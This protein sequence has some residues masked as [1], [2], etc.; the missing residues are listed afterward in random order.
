V[1]RRLIGAAGLVLLAMTSAGCSRWDGQ[2]P[3]VL[4]DAEHAGTKLLVPDAHA[5]ACRTRVLGLDVGEPSSPL[6]RAV[7]TLLAVDPEADALLNL[8]VAARGLALGVFERSRVA[9][10]PTS[11]VPRPSY[12]SL[13]PPGTRVTTDDT[14]DALRGVGQCEIRRTPGQEVR[15]DSQVGSPRA[16]PGGRA[17][18]GRAADGGCERKSDGRDLDVDG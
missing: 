16:C 14:R 18:D 3:L 2:L 6:D 11:C 15:D 4:S 1:P 17:C 9:M 13:R 5:A 8:R 12:V 7:R 10:M